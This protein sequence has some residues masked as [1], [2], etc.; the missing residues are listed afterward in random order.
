MLNSV[1]SCRHNGR[2]GKFFYHIVPGNEKRIHYHNPKYRR[3]SGKPSHISTSVAKLNILGSKLLLCIWWDQLGVVYYELLKPT[4]TLM[5]DC[6]QRQLMCLSST[7]KR[8]Q[9]LY[10]QRYNKVI[11]QHDNARPHVAK[12]VKTYLETLK[13]EV[14]P[15]LPYLTDIALFDYHLFQLMTHDLAKQH[16]HS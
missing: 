2:K 16:F 11:L 1:L 10:E 8:N 6:Y 15:H 9:L 5:G 3:S 7:L 4:K 13:W 12:W 14:L